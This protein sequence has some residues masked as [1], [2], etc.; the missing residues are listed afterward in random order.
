MFMTMIAVN[1]HE[2]KAKFSEYLEAAA[3][4]ER[5]VICKRNRPIVELR[6]VEQTRVE[7]RPV[8]PGRH[9]FA[10]PDAFFNPM[11]DEFL[12]AFE[13]GVVYPEIGGQAGRV[14]EPAASPYGSSSKRKRR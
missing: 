6:A 8:G 11:P 12:E 14:A 1:I 4:G 7:P 9:R 3:N 2:A 13:S 5:V 10:V